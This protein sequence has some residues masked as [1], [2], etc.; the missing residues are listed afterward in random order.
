MQD[1]SVISKRLAG[2]EFSYYNKEKIKAMSQQEIY[3][4]IAFDH[5]FRPISHGLYDPAMGVSPYDHLSKCVTCGL[6]ELQCPGHLGHIELTAPVYNV[7]LFTILYKLLR[8][9]CFN[10]HKFRLTDHKRLYFALKFRLIKLGMLKEAAQLGYLSTAIPTVLPKSANERRGSQEGSEGSTLEYT[11]EDLGSLIVEEETKKKTAKKKEDHPIIKK[12]KEEAE[13]AKSFE[14]LKIIEEAKTAEVQEN[15]TAIEKAWKDAIKEFWMTVRASK[16]CP[17]CQAVSFNIKKDGYTKFFRVPLSEKEKSAMKVLG[18]DHE[19]ITY[20]SL[21]FAEEDEEDSDTTEGGEKTFSQSD[22]EMEAPPEEKKEDTKAKQVYMHPLEIKEHITKLWK[23]ESELMDLMFGR[24]VKHSGSGKVQGRAYKHYSVQPN[25]RDMFFV[26]AIVVPPNRFRPES[27]GDGDEALLHRHTV[28]LTRILNLNLALKNML[29]G[30][31]QKELGK[32]RTVEE[33]EEIMQAKTT[34]KEIHKKALSSTDIVKKWI[35]LQDAINVFMDSSKA[36]RTTI[37]QEN[38]GLRQLLERKEGLF[39]MKMMGKR[40]NFAARSVISPDPYIDTNEIGIPQFMA[41]KL[42]YPETVAAYNAHKLRKLVTNGADV[43]PGANIVEDEKGIKI[44]LSALSKEQRKGLAK[45]LTTGQKTVYRHMETGDILMFN[46]QPTLHRPSIMG[47]KARVLP[48]EQTIRMHYSNCASYNADFDGDEMNAHLV[49]NHVARAEGYNLMSTDYQYIV[50]TSGRP[51][52]GLIQDTV[53]SGVY[54]TAKGTLLSKSLFQ[55]LV[56]IAL[57]NVLAAGFVKQIVIPRPAILKPVERWT[58]KQVITSILKSLITAV[59]KTKGGEGKHRKLGLYLTSKS[60][61]PASVW[62]PYGAEEGSVVIMNCELLCGVL[63]KSQF[64]ATEFGLVHAFHELY[65]PK[66]AAELLNCLGKLFTAFLQIHGFTCPMNHLILNQKAEKTRKKLIEEAFTK[67]VQAAGHFAGQESDPDLDV[68]RNTI[69][70]GIEQKLIL[71][72]K[73]DAELDQVMKGELNACTSKINK[74]CL[75]SG[76]HETFPANFMSAMVLSG[77]KGS[78]VNHTQISCLLG[79]QELEGRRVPIT[80]AGR[81]LPSFLPYDPHPRAG[82]FIADRFLSGLKPQEFFFHCMAGREGLVD[83]AVKT[84]RSG[85]LQRCLIKQLESLIVNYDMTVRDAD[86]SVIQFYYGEDGIDPTK[87][88]YMDQFKF[89]TENYVPILH[90]YDIKNALKVLDRKKAKTMRMEG[91]VPIMENL[92]PAVNFG[93]ISEKQYE[94]IHKYKTANPDKKLRT[95]DESE[96]VGAKKLLS[97]SSFEKLCNF[98]YF[99]SLMQPGENVGIIASQ[100]IG[101]P[102]TQMTLNTF[103]LAGHGGVNVTLGIPRLREILMTAGRIKTPTMVLPPLPGVSKQAM[104]QVANR[105]KRV[106]LQEIVKDVEIVHKIETDQTKGIAVHAYHITIELESIP[107]I[108]ATFDVSYKTIKTIFTDQLVPLL[109]SIISKELRKSKETAKKANDIQ[110]RAGNEHKAKVAAEE[111]DENAE[112]LKTNAKRQKEEEVGDIEGYEGTKLLFKKKE[113]ADYEEED[114]GKDD[115]GEGLQKMII[116]Q[117][118]EKTEIEKKPRKTSDVSANIK[119]SKENEGVFDIVLSF[120]LECKK[121]LLMEIVQKAMAQVMLRSRKGIDNCLLV[122]KTAANG[123]KETVIQTQG[124]NWHAAYEFKEFIDLKRIEC[125]DIWEVL[126]NYG[127][128]AA[129]QTI[130]REIK[131]VFG[132]Y[133]INIDYRH[134]S[135]VADF[136]THNGEYRPFNRVGMEENA[137]P[138]LKMSFETTVSYLTKSAST[139]DQDTGKS[140]SSSIVLGQVP[141]IGTGLFDLQYSAIQPFAKYQ[142]HLLFIPYQWHS[143]SIIIPRRLIKMERKLRNELKLARKVS[144]QVKRPKSSTSKAKKAQAPA[145]QLTSEEI[146]RV[147]KELG[148]MRRLIKKHKKKKRP[149]HSSECG[150]SE[151]L[152]PENRYLHVI[153]PSTCKSETTLPQSVTYSSFNVSTMP[154]SKANVPGYS[155]QNNIGGLHNFVPNSSSYARDPRDGNSLKIWLDDAVTLPSRKYKRRKKRKTTSILT[156]KLKDNHSINRHASQH[157]RLFSP[158]LAWQSGML[159]PTLGSNI[160]LRR[161]YGDTAKG[162]KRSITLLGSSNKTIIKKFKPR[163]AVRPNRTALVPFL[164]IDVKPPTNFPSVISHK[165]ESTKNNFYTTLREKPRGNSNVVREIE[166]RAARVI[167]KAIR[168]HQKKKKIAQTIGRADISPIKK[169][170]T[171]TAKSARRT[172]KSNSKERGRME[173]GIE[174]IETLLKNKLALRDKRKIKK[175]SKVMDAAASFVHEE[176]RALGGNGSSFKGTPDKSETIAMKSNKG[177]ESSSKASN[178]SPTNP[179]TLSLSVKPTTTINEGESN[180][181]SEL[182]GEETGWKDT[183]NMAVGIEELVKEDKPELVIATFDNPAVLPIKNLPDPEVHPQNVFIDREVTPH[184][185]RPHAANLMTP[186]FSKEDCASAEAFID[187][188]QENESELYEYSNN[189]TE[190]DVGSIS[191]KAVKRGHLILWSFYFE[192]LEARSLA[193]SVNPDNEKTISTEMVAAI[194]GKWDVV[195]CRSIKFEKLITEGKN[196]LCGWSHISVLIPTCLGIFRTLSRSALEYGLPLWPDSVD[197]PEDKDQDAIHESTLEDFVDRGWIKGVLSP[198]VDIDSTAKALSSLESAYPR[199]SLQIKALANISEYATWALVRRLEN[200]KGKRLG[201]AQTIEL[202]SKDIVEECLREIAQLFVLMRDLNGK[203]LKLS[204]NPIPDIPPIQRLNLVKKYTTYLEPVFGKLRKIEYDKQSMEQEI[205]FNN[206]S[207][208]RLSNDSHGFNT[209]RVKYSFKQR[210]VTSYDIVHSAKNL[211]NEREYMGHSGFASHKGQEGDQEEVSSEESMDYKNILEPMQKLDDRTE[212]EEKKPLT[213]MSSYSKTDRRDFLSQEVE[214]LIKVKET[215][216]NA[217]HFSYPFCKEYP[218]KSQ[219]YREVLDQGMVKVNGKEI[220]MLALCIAVDPFIERVDEINDRERAMGIYKIQYQSKDA[221]VYEN[222]E[223]YSPGTSP[224]FQADSRVDEPPKLF[225]TPIQPSNIFCET[226]GGVLT[227]NCVKFLF[228]HPK[229]PKVVQSLYLSFREFADL[230]KDSGFDLSEFIS[231]GRLTK[232]ERA[233]FYKSLR[234][235]CYWVYD[236]VYVKTCIGNQASANKQRQNTTWCEGEDVYKKN[237]LRTKLVRLNQGSPFIEGIMAKLGQ[238]IVKKSH[239]IWENLDLSSK[240]CDSLNR[241]GVYRKRCILGSNCFINGQYY[242]VGINC[243]RLQPKLAYIDISMS[244][245]Y[246]PLF[247]QH[248]FL[249]DDSNVVRAYCNIQLRSIGQ[250]IW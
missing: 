156:N 62:G 204:R 5:L 188:N 27:K 197:S 205:H 49:Q 174:S 45:T 173:E 10:C 169:R 90:K 17:L 121:I 43:Y 129:R 217:R 176:N 103:H 179:Q 22:S 73:A 138:F 180:K 11:E 51:I 86:G 123:K 177:V 149:T 187:P 46:R 160:N 218:Q 117:E 37:A 105:L 175:N 100:A 171:K 157:T 141:R 150:E 133:G 110:V 87:A 9:K 161:I 186:Q 126:R 8:S 243:I 82:G 13:E 63:D 199:C 89:I 220:V 61:L 165:S 238:L 143:Q 163:C 101:E 42:T 115:D 151:K 244:N 47:H 131:T 48:R 56:Y 58:G 240:I 2:V 25:D 118:E 239:S 57:H 107:A 230:F 130:V 12:F 16:K 212:I 189:Q 152:L 158:K 198:E 102:S 91:K 142:Y 7:F 15:N 211:T 235:R 221:I 35:E 127:V 167:Q 79:Q 122:D 170:H 30:K 231:L 207:G 193:E 53:V 172:V 168:K 155:F 66:M 64:G 96:E 113:F 119:C 135:L 164:S 233:A 192:E 112:M 18:I 234:K 71:E 76:L 19:N 246:R 237:S 80:P 247:A 59:D 83:T 224:K 250:Q 227:N 20:D 223:D 201:S 132:V 6:G 153:A 241:M 44:Q 26:S 214:Q 202:F 203:K 232:D 74:S 41:K 159:S 70:K 242:F 69:R 191:I 65:G 24:L 93:A 145:Q 75:P 147:L 219:P 154:S 195:A 32:D 136:M 216:S 52:R 236:K 88:K 111:E 183:Q 108:T 185:K 39:R 148:K 249:C 72:D 137:S 38:Q 109:V 248:I 229:N 31:E 78:E 67:G 213:A 98:K 60:K 181:K 208:F 3:T 92:N 166:H 209:E 190:V 1:A 125:N 146:K 228:V 182:L 245:L 81:S 28:M 14:L 94:K 4:P 200:A 184:C 40:V 134:L 77:A 34:A 194:V 196:P 206:T 54:L 95:E 226:F 99:Y 128:E 84:S 36:M 55:E 97:A 222:Q 215:L 140:P 225:T 139:R 178:T 120:P 50:P 144:P 106:R 124:I 114:E 21:P 85:Y 162:Q 23:I 68:S 29:L 104:Q 116:E 33:I 210:F